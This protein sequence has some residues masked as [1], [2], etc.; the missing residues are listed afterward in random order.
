MTLQLDINGSPARHLLKML[1]VNVQTN[2]GALGAVFATTGSISASSNTL[3]ITGGALPAGII[4]GSG[5]GIGGA[6][7]PDAVS[8]P[9]FPTPA[10]IASGWT[11]PALR[12]R[13]TAISGSTVTLSVAA[14]SSLRQRGRAARRM[15]TP[16]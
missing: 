13:V 12:A 6:G 11:A 8:A 3:T 10:D 1:N 15:H 7:T 4:V 14:G 5:L 2:Y 16:S 9:Y